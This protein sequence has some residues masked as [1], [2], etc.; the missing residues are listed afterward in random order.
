MERLRGPPRRTRPIYHRYEWR[1]LIAH[2]FGHRGVY[3]A[4]E[5]EGG[6]LRGVL[7]MIRLRSAL[8]G[9]FLVSMPY[10]NYGGVL[11]EDD[12]V[13]RGPPR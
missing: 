4:A 7:P 9:D 8:F 12:G 6:A 1:T 2:V 3:F 10:F 5:G 13:A 11:A